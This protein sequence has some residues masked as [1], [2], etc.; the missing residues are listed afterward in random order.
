MQS[1]SRWFGVALAAL[2]WYGVEFSTAALAVAR[3]Q[4]PDEPRIARL[5]RELGAESFAAR[6]AANQALLQ[7]GAAGRSALEAAVQST[8]PE[9]RL[10]ARDL[11]QRLRTE[12]LWSAGPVTLACR[13]APLAKIVEQLGQQAGNHL[14]V[15]E[16]YGRF[17]DKTI[18]LALDK[19]PYWQ[20]IDEI[21]RQSDNHVRPHY[22]PRRP[23]LV[24]VAGPPGNN[25]VAYGGPLRATIIDA[26][27]AFQEDLDFEEGKSQ[28]AHTFQFNL[29]LL[30]E[31]RFRVVAYRS[32]PDV[33]HAVTD[34]GAV[35]AAMVGEGPTWSVA[36]GG[37]RQL[38]TTLKLQP[39][40]R[41]AR[42]LR[43]LTLSWELIA[44]GEMA[45]LEVK[46]LAA[47]QRHRRDDV[48]LV[49]ERIEERPGGRY[50]LTAVV[51][52][53][54]VHPE[55]R[56]ALLHENQIEL[57]DAEGRA[58]QNYGE[59]SALADDGA[60]LTV[61]FQAAQADSKPAMLRLTYPQ[62]RSQR[63]VEIKFKDVPLPVTWPD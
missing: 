11:L 50:L 59:N 26:R 57:F 15:G 46:D 58:L 40:L 2:G 8:D 51:S 1:R 12:Q 43:E 47:S 39:P 3:A 45:T 61:T 25:P 13:E 4:S 14:L 18:S 31:D 6:Q 23:G 63:A 22:N 54:L 56:E 33:V 32:G 9:V 28:V 53:D 55:P 17:E 41:A 29:Q 37:V 24:L 5:V 7:L 60:R 19:A 42:Q 48:E 20:A 52:R 21:C 34:Q 10:R 30:W 35:L 49:I 38:S 36:P 44:V 62:V 16:Q 27:R